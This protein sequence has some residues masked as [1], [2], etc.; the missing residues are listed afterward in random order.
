MPGREEA[1]GQGSGRSGAHGTSL[2]SATVSQPAAE[3][4]PAVLQAT[5]HPARVSHHTES[6]ERLTLIPGYYFLSGAQKVEMITENLNTENQCVL[7]TQ[8]GGL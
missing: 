1:L 5:G 3:A 6:L 4:L 7:Q 2:K 8:T